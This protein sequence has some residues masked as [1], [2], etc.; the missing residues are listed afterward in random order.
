MYFLYFAAIEQ[1]QYCYLE[2]EMPKVFVL[3]N[4]LGFLRIQVKPRNYLYNVVSLFCFISRILLFLS[5]NKA[6]QI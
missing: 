6:I 3:T 1:Q 4:D 2:Q 5:R